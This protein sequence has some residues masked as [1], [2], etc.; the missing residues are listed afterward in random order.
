MTDD[1]IRSAAE[2]LAHELPLTGEPSPGVIGVIESAF[3]QQRAEAEAIM[4]WQECDSFNALKGRAEAAEAE[5]EHQRVHKEEYRDMLTAAEVECSRLRAALD[6]LVTKLTA[7]AK[8]LN[9]LAVLAYVHGMPYQ[10]PNW[11]DEM[12]AARAALQVGEAIPQERG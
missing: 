2:Q 12:N 10:G 1:P 6:G 7:M 4:N 3:R 11:D 8:P 9:S 5:V